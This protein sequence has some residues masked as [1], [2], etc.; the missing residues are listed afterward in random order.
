MFEILHLFD[1]KVSEVTVYPTFP[2]AE[3][4]LIEPDVLATNT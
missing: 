1:D 2:I 4:K 3:C